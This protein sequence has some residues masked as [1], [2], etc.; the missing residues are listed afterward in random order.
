MDFAKKG[1]GVRQIN[2]HDYEV[3][4]INLLA[5][6]LSKE[7]Q[8][9]ESAEFQQQAAVFAADLPRRVRS[10]LDNYRRT[11]KDSVIVLSGIR[12]DDAEI[13]PT[14]QAR[15]ATPVPSPTIVC[16]IAFYL[17]GCLLGDPIGWATQQNGRLMHDIFPVPDHE[18]EQIGWGSAEELTWHTEDA[19][20]P[21]RPDYLGLLCLRNPDMVETTVAEIRDV[22]IGPEFRDIL[23][24]PL[25]RIVPDDSHRLHNANSPA[26]E[27]PRAGVLRRR[28]YKMVERLAKA[29]EPVAVLFGDDVAPY[30]RVD[31]F[32]MQCAQGEREQQAL[33]ELAAAVNDAL[34]GVILQPGD[35]CFIDNYRAV[36][37]RKAFYARFDGTDRWL[38][39]LNITRDLRKSRAHRI[40]ADSRVIY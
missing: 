10:A 19:F 39:R 31:P 36:H 23:S 4:A 16:D 14:P 35:I 28:S 1:H 15:R 3:A 5:S 7:Y 22:M 2:L 30:L 6:E 12:A 25:F 32:Y 21:L 8:T 18:H 34:S 20:H 38:R 24:Q 40:S 11:E 9:V 13:G 37:G 29:P 33:D 17:F 27:D 26:D